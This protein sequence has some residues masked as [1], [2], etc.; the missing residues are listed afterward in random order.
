MEGEQAER[1]CSFCNKRQGQVQRLLAGSRGVLICDEC[2]M[3]S[4]QAIGE[5]R[6]EGA[7]SDS[8]PRRHRRFW[9]R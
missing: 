9:E 3:V 8:K 4:S 1:R 7:A 6:S 5:E 2:V